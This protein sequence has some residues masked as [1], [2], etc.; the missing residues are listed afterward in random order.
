MEHSET[1]RSAQITEQYF[2]FL[3][4]HVEDV[5][6]GNATDFLELNQIANALH[7]THSHLSDSLQKTTGHHPCHFYDMKIIEKAKSL[8]KETDLS[9]A[10]IAKKLTYDPSNFSKFF[11]KF[12]GQTAGE[13]R[14]QQKLTNLKVPKSSP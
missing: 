1:K 6:N 7:I 11:K 2:A 3:D 10:F 13:F 12:T 4:R 9:I 5:A 8:L 14:K